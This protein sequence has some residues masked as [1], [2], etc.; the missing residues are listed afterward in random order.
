MQNFMAKGASFSILWGIIGYQFNLFFKRAKWRKQEKQR[1][2]KEEEDETS[3]T[4]NIING[5]T[6]S[7]ENNILCSTSNN[8]FT[9][10]I[11]ANWKRG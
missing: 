6:C 7:S 1:K 10:G 8:N 3:A 4:I 2:L 5:L 9:E 11:E